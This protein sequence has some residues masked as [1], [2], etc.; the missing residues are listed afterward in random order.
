MARFVLLYSWV[1]SHCMSVCERTWVCVYVSH[2]LDSFIGRHV[3][4]L[5]ILAVVNNAVVNIG[6]HSLLKLVLWFSLD[7]DPV[8]E[9][10]DCIV[11][12]LLVLLRNLHRFFTVDAPSYIPTNNAWGFS[13]LHSLISTCYGCLFDNNHSDR[14]EVVSH[15]FYSHFPDDVDLFLYLLA[16]YVFFGKM[17]IQI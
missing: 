11:V 6:M 16:I 13:F 9:L 1:I 12:L 4:C 8:V 3:G 7:K 10:L 2:L 5:C 14:C 17:S 15:S